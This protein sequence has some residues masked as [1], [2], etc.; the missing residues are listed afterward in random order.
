MEFAFSV[1]LFSLSIVTGMLGIGVAIA[2]VPVLSLGLDE[3]INQ[4]HPLSLLL[5][6]VTAMFSAIAFS[7]AKLIRWRPAAALAIVATASAP[8]GALAARVVPESL[9]WT[10]YFAAVAFLCYRMLAT[11]PDTPARLNLRAILILA[12]PA[13]FVSGFAG[14]GAG[15]LLVPLMIHFGF[16]IRQAAAINAVAVTPSSFAAALPHLGH[17]DLPFG[18]VV[19]LCGA[20]ALGSMIGGALASSKVS[21]TILR[22]VFVITILGTAGA[23]AVRMLA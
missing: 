18:F 5:N 19:A 2:A 22:R 16:G 4:V 10:V 3:L 20:G 13:A 12:V 9:V 11:Q 21:P 15:F 7:R 17:M 1:A 14:V 23:R 8:L 6:G